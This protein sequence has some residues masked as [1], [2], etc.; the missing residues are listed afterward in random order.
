MVRQFW[1]KVFR[2]DWDKVFEKY[3]AKG[4]EKKD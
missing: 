3:V 2:I 4:A 1:D